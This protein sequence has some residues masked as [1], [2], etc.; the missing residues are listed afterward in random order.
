MRLSLFSSKHYSRKKP[1]KTT[2]MWLF[3]VLS[4]LKLTRAIELAQSAFSSRSTKIY[5]KYK[6]IQIYKANGVQLCGVWLT[7]MAWCMLYATLRTALIQYQKH[8]ASLVFIWLRFGTLGC[9]ALCV[10]L[11]LLVSFFISSICFSFN[12]KTP[13]ILYILDTRQTNK[14]TKHNTI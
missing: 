3:I 10:L 8:F 5:N 9:F 14:Q 6:Y 1:S 7:G 2:A 11:V 4:E 13:Y 12:W